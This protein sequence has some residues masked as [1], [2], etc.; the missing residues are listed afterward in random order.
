MIFLFTVV[1]LFVSS[2]NDKVNI[3]KYIDFRTLKNTYFQNII[4]LEINERKN[5]FQAKEIN[6]NINK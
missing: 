5:L 4:F 1:P 6:R 3:E 2:D